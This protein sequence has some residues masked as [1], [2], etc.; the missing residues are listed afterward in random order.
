MT[1]TKTQQIMLISNF[2]SMRPYIDK[3]IKTASVISYVTKEADK[4]GMDLYFASDTVN[5]KKCASSTDVESE[6]K[7][8]KIVDGTCDMQNCLLNV[9][10]PVLVPNMRPTS[11]YVFTDAIWEPENSLDAIIRMCIEHL[12][13]T[14]ERPSTL[15][16]QFIQ[17]GEDEH[18][19]K[20]LHHLDDDCAETH[21]PV[22]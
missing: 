4:D 21:G 9:L 2:S 18:G 6:V 1:L 10:E 19:T 11:I 13:K 20:L 22:R 14:K 3:V 16:L 8:M 12:V 15:M 7:K 17:F 5:A